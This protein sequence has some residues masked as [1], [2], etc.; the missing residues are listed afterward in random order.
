MIKTTAIATIKALFDQYGTMPYF[1]EEIS[2][3]EH[4][5]QAALLAEA[6]DADDD[7][8]VAAFLHDIGHLIPSEVPGEH[9]EGYGRRDHEGLAAEWLL[10][11]GFSEKTAALVANHVNAKRYLVYELPGY[12]NRLSEASRRTLEFQGGAMTA[13][14]ADRFEQHPH[15]KAILQMR[16]WDEEAKVLDMK[17]PEIDYFI[18]IIERQ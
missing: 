14:E 16:Y 11:Q 1:G 2:Q 3:Y 12:Y 10:Q 5:A 7:T 18:K 8:I 6:A 4:A 13:S 17:L 15:F 9:M